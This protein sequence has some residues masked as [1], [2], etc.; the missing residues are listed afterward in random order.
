MFLYCVHRFFTPLFLIE[1]FA[2]I[3]GYWAVCFISGETYFSTFDS[4]NPIAKAGSRIAKTVI[5][6]FILLKKIGMIILARRK[7]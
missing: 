5:F 4:E 7:K 6:V 3:R 1:K 2:N